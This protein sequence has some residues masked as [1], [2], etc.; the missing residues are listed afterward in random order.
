MAKLRGHG[1]DAGDEAV[2]SPVLSPVDAGKLAPVLA[3]QSLAG[4]INP[5]AVVSEVSGSAQLNLS[6][7]QGILIT[8]RVTFQQGVM[9]ISR[10]SAVFEEAKSHQ[11]GPDNSFCPVL[12]QGVL[13]SNGQGVSPLLT[14]LKTHTARGESPPPLTRIHDAG[15]IVRKHFVRKWVNIAT[16][17]RIRRRSSF[18]QIRMLQTD[19]VCSRARSGEKSSP[20]HC[21]PGEMY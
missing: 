18:I 20:L 7:Y 12:S 2:W 11:Y 19:R 8:Y 4:K 9:K 14:M 21:H 10:V 15:P 13:V 6:D 1:C 16:D 17:R 5:D 3:G